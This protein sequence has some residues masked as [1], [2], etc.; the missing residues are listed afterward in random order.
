MKRPAQTSLQL[1][2]IA[3]A[4]DF[5]VSSGERENTHTLTTQEHKCNPET[6][7]KSTKPSRFS[8]VWMATTLSTIYHLQVQQYM[9]SEQCIAVNFV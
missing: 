8:P 4:I 5:Q 3:K 9:N 6:H 1:T 2:K 7:T